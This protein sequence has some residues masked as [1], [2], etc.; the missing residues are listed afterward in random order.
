MTL[1]GTSLLDGTD[2]VRVSGRTLQF[3][4]LT[5]PDGIQENDILTLFYV[6]DISLRGVANRK[7]PQVTVEYRAST[8]LVDR[9]TL[10]VIDLSGNTVYQDSVTLGKE[11]FGI[12]SVTLKSYVPKPGKYEYEIKSLKEYKLL[13]GK[14]LTK[15]NKTSRYPFEMPAAVFYDESGAYEEN[16]NTNNN[17]NISPSTY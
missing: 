2:F 13:N 16:N 6:T 3:L 11:V 5:E 17:N 7:Q 12:Q 14:T 10:D 9:L 1:N 8:A 4:T 15:M